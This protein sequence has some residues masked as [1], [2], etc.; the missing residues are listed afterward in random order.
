MFRTF[1]NITSTDC[2]YSPG[3][4]LERLPVRHAKD[5]KAQFTVVNEHFS[6][7]HNEAS[8]LYGQTLVNLI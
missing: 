7:E 6:E 4:G 2:P 5:E 3:S 1:A 8:G